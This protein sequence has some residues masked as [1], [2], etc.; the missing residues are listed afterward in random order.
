MVAQDEE[1]SAGYQ[2]KLE[3]IPRGGPGGTPYHVAK[4]VKFIANFACDTVV[5][6]DFGCAG[7]RVIEESVRGF[8]SC[9]IQARY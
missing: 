6:A 3:G 7:H 2:R 4:T 9:T 1:D 8:Y 5:C